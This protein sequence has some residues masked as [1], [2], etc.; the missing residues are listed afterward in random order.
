M[1]FIKMRL[2]L[3]VLSLILIIETSAQ[4]DFEFMCKSFTQNANQKKC[5]IVGMTTADKLIAYINNNY[6]YQ[7]YRDQV[8]SIDFKLSKMSEMIPLILSTFTSLQSFDASGVQ[9]LSIQRDDFKNSAAVKELNVSNNNLTTLGNM[10]F[11]ALKSLQTLDLSNNAIESFHDGAFEDCS[12]NLRS[13]NLSFNKVKQMKLETFISLSVIKHIALFMDYNE[14]VEIPKQ[15]DL[16]NKLTFSAL[17]FKSNK[18]AYFDCSSFNVTTLNLNNNQLEEAVLNCTIKDVSIAHNKLKELTIGG[19][20]ESV[21]ASNNSLI[22]IT[23]DD[24]D[25]IWKLDLAG[26]KKVDNILKS[27]KEIKSMKYL[28]LSDLFLGSLS[29][30]SFARMPDLEI[31][32]L[33]NTG[34]SN[35]DYGTFAYQKKLK[36]LDIGG[37]QLKEIDFHMYTAL[38]SLEYFDISNNN[39][40]QFDNVEIIKAVFPAL[41]EIDIN[42]NIWNCSYLAK[43]EIAFNREGIA[44]KTPS[45]LDKNSSH[46]MGIECTKQT[47]SRIQL[48]P[49]D[50]NE[51]NLKFN[52]MV[53][54]M[55]VS[56]SNNDLLKL[57]MD[58]IQSKLFKLQNDYL[59]VKTQLLQTQLTN[60]NSTSMSVGTVNS[61]VRS[62]VEE[63]NKTTLDKQNLAHDKVTQKINELQLE[64]KTQQL[65]AEKVA[66]KYQIL[67][68]MYKKNYLNTPPIS[69]RSSQ[70]ESLKFTF[71]ETLLTLASVLIIIFCVLKLKQFYKNK[72]NK[73]TQISKA[74]SQNTLNT[75][76]DNSSV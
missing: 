73:K 70:E 22:E 55:E 8:R 45:V 43:M 59:E 39:L 23:I 40:T 37:N 31:L 54:R 1:N 11:S 36:T 49:E 63:I 53:K 28:D 5:S 3:L 74:C 12:K 27:I 71:T 34:I 2:K 57:D 17:S 50:G 52:E 48:L 75:V 42:Q 4:S 46:I 29:V 67:N 76:Y 21:V 20:V 62:I 41:I 61:S 15:T 38:K 33:K 24:N 9:L 60:L 30:D 64:L 16:N 51:I 32:K 6:N 72:Y 10:V 26:N 18:L 58:V 68:E 65:E 13:V 7:S 19:T 56:S 47:Y 69:Q 66:T 44:V 14:I 35:I 25:V